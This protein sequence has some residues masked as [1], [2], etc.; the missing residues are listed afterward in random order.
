[1]S[2]LLEFSVIPT[3]CGESISP[4]VARCLEVV[5]ASGLTYRVGPMGTTIEGQSAREVFNVVEQCLSA[6]QDDCHRVEV[7]MNLDWRIGSAPRLE[8]KVASVVE[9]VG[10]PLSP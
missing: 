8:A 3:D 6:T 10:P 1:M 2:V 5:E 7:M 4:V 9:K